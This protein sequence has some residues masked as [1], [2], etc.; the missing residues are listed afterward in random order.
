VFKC[1]DL[2]SDPEH[3]CKKPGVVHTLSPVGREKETDRDRDRD[4]E[5]DRERASAHWST[6]V[7]QPGQTEKLPVQVHFHAF[8]NTG[9]MN[10]ITFAQM[11]GG[12]PEGKIRGR[13]G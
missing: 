1:V 6:V 9:K 10:S 13:K 12:V 2:S 4:R 7:S 5:R 3:L 8:G 11:E